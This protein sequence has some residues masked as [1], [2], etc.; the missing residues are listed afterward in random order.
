MILPLANGMKWK[1]SDM[2]S[3]T[4]KIHKK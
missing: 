2:H 3:Q 4:A 1:I